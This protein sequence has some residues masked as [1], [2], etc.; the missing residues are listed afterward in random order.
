MTDTAPAPKFCSECGAPLSPTAKFCHACGHQVGAAAP[1][2]PAPAVPASA[3]Q[4]SAVE[5]EDT[6]PPAPLVTRAKSSA[7]ALPWLLGLA[8]LIAGSAY[9][10]TT[11]PKPSEA[12]APPGM[13]APFA[14]GGS[15]AAPPDIA[16]M[17]PNERANRLYGRIMAYVQAGKADS[18]AFFAP[19]ALAAHEMLETKSID[20]RYHL[21]QINEMLGNAAVAAAHADTILKA[22]PENLLGLM[23]ATHAAR[24]ANKA[25]DIK[26]F[27]A[28]FL[29]VLDAQ[30]ATKKPEYD[31]HKAEIDRTAAEARGGK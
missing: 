15:G 25:A 7:T 18:A 27:D 3:V 11:Q 29:K 30:L 6:A 2:V 28:L 20:E 19:M 10:A 21:G 31:M 23:L 26:T 5:D 9:L 22:E 14:N 4:A 24:L 16:N 17:S 1:A 8:G 13:A 12:A